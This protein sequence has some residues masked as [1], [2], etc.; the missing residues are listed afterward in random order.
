MTDSRNRRNGFGQD[1]FTALFDPRFWDNLE[2]KISGGIEKSLRGI[3]LRKD[4][5]VVAEATETTPT[6]VREILVATLD[7]PGVA[8]ED[9]AVEFSELDYGFTRLVITTKRGE[10]LTSVKQE[11]RESI[12]AEKATAAVDLGVLTV[13]VPVKT[14]DTKSRFEVPVV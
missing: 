6:E 2:K 8:K 10:E 9:V 5:E 11:F 13:R 7:I 1:P 12:V 3:S 14:D 4:V